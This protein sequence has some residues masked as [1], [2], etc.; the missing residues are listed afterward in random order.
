MGRLVLAGANVWDAAEGSRRATVVVDGKRIVEVA[1]EVQLRPDD[2]VVDRGL[3]PGAGRREQRE[4][5]SQKRGHDRGRRPGQPGADHARPARPA[6]AATARSTA[7]DLLTDSW[8]P[9]SGSESATTPP[10][11]WT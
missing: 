4:R 8:C 7:M 2:R 9:A 1:A 10:P 6:A 11:A 3:H 5:G